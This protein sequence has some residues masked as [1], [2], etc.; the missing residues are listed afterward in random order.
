MGIA[1]DRFSIVPQA[2]LLEK[3]PIVKQADPPADEHTYQP[4]WKLWHGLLGLGALCVIFALLVA[5]NMTAAIGFILGGLVF[6]G[7]Q[8]LLLLW[9]MKRLRQ[10]PV[11]NEGRNR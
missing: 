4:Q 7:I 8:A 3:N 2:L 5:F 11:R 1:A 9:V 6:L 10:Q